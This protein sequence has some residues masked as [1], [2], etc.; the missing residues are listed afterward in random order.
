MI[1][2]LI[3]AFTSNQPPTFAIL[4]RAESPPDRAVE[5]MVGPFTTVDRLADLPL[6]TPP[7]PARCKELLAVIPFRQA[8]ER[9]FSV[10][11]DQAPLLVMPITE[12]ATA[13]R[14]QIH[15]LLPAVPIHVSEERFIP[16]DDEYEALVKRIIDE[17]IGTGEGANFVIK[18]DYVS[19]FTCENRVAG[20]LSLF[21]EL[22]EQE[23]G[24]YWTFVIY[25]GT[26]V[27]VG[28]S[29][30][31]HISVTDTV[32]VMNP[33]SGTYRYP[34]SGPSVAD[35]MAFLE[36]Q[37]ESNEL[38]MVLDEELKMMARICPRGGTVSGPMLREMS[39]LAHTEYFIRGRTE[40]DP[41]DIL[42]ETLFA[43]TISGS[44]LQN[45][46]RVISRYEPAGRMYYSGVLAL[47]ETGETGGRNLDSAIM[48]RTADISSDGLLRIGVGSTIVRDSDPAAEAAETRGKAASL[49]CALKKAGR[50]EMKSHPDVVTSLRRRNESIAPF[51]FEDA[52][53]RLQG[54]QE[55]AGTSVL[56]FDAE[57]SFTLMIA[58]QLE[59]LGL[60]VV[61]TKAEGTVPVDGYDLAIFGPGPGNPN[62]RCDTRIETLHHTIRACLA[63]RHPFAAVCLSHQI[64]SLQLGLPVVPRGTPN[65]GVQKDIDLFG[66]RRAV[67]FYN[68]FA[69]FSQSDAFDVRDLGRIEVS[70]DPTTDEVH[71]IRGGWFTS[72]QFHPESVLTQNGPK[73]LASMIR[74]V[75]SDRRLIRVGADDAPVHSC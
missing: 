56:V 21:R 59:S 9:G 23:R 24:A 18:R 48:I 36:D 17:A 14:D 3:S 65:Q 25:T 15:A 39:H 38:Y 12:T 53:G 19:H 42:R 64:L 69:A 47:I 27:F 75:I 70:R 55:F 49:I 20:A 4:Y 67:G 50:A 43:P 61:V 71:A 16:P 10:I 7:R 74:H 35:L 73:I 62:D 40:I 8:T 13:S 54:R 26:Q 32:A 66:V 57:D 22:L 34:P 6:A 37:K 11:D 46:F 60:R 68:T 5:V 41:R 31:R 1:T 28:A 45:A 44:P 72:T 2:D 58:Q 63:A 29:P 30:E 52:D 51:W 33:I